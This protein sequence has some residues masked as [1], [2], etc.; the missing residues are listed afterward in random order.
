[1]EYWLVIIFAIIAIAAIA[2]LL[3]YELMGDDAVLFKKKHRRGKYINDQTAIIYQTIKDTVDSKSA[4]ALFIE[5]LF[6]NHKQFLEYIKKTLMDIRKSYNADNISGLESTI[7]DIK[8]MKIE[9]KDQRVAQSDCISTID[10]SFYI[11]FVAWIHLA[12]NCRFSINASLK[13][14]AE[15]CIDYSANYSEPFPDIYN[16]QLEY[17]V[18]DICNICNTALSLIGSNDV[19]AMRE[20]RKR[21]SIILDE[22]YANSQRL[23][24]LIH[25]GRSELDPDRLTA[26]KYALN[27]FQELHNIIYT[28]RRFVLANICLTLSLK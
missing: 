16:E 2:I 23:F 4:Y 27:A 20:L 28:L 11:E 12:N 5:Y 26:L 19:D 1:M 7:S 13:R 9:L 25:D 15:V 22:S 17:L 21:M 24:E 8:E 3:F 14:M 18:A 10:R 6:A